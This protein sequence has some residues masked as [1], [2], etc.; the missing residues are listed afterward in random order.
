MAII[1]ALNEFVR[2]SV[3]LALEPSREC[4][5]GCTYCFA[6]LNSKSQYAARSKSLVDDTSFERTLERAWLPSHDP[7][8]FIQWGLRN[9]LVL[10]Y[11]N[12]VEPFQDVDQGCSILSLCERFNIPL[13]IQTKGVNFFEVVGCLSPFIDNSSLFISL[14]SLD[15][16]VVKRFEPGTPPIAERLRVIECLRDMGFWVIAALSPY[17]ED[18][19]KDPKAL[20]D[21]LAD[22]GV[23]EIFLDRLH[24]SNR[25]SGAA[26]D[27]TMVALA[28]NGSSGWPPRAIDHLRIIHEA[29]LANDIHF[30]ANGFTNTCYGYFNTL[31][32]ISPDSCFSRGTP[33]PYHDGDVFRTLEQSFYDSEITPVSRSEDFSESIILTWNDIISIIHNNGF[34][35]QEFS[36]S[37][38]MDIVPLYKKVPD[39]W[40]RAVFGADPLKGTATMAEIFRAIY[41]SP[42]RHQFIW[43]HPWIKLACDMKGNPILDDAGNLIGLFDPDYVNPGLSRKVESLELFRSLEYEYSDESK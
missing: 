33:W 19:N 40:K 29:C 36:Y 28:G 20:V 4:V 2:E 11:A 6:R 14:P 42:Y 1:R 8:H 30:F 26:K 23:N 5:A 37:S 41:N 9:N 21:Q 16:R 17:H 13:F 18:W 35:G 7:T 3:V 25:Q 43:R 34:I 10:G 12:T 32:T 15:D 24:I 22:C 39:I 31:P 38:L 27:K